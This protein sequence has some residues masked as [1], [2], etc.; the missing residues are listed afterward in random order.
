MQASLV[1]RR[2]ASVTNGA[3]LVNG[4]AG[5][6]SSSNTG[7]SDDGDRLHQRQS[8]T[9]A[10]TSL[11][12]EQEEE[13][14]EVAREELLRLHDV[15]FHLQ[16]NRYIFTGYR[17]LMTSW[18]CLKS[19][20]YWHNE[21]INIL[22]HGIPLVLILVSIPYM[23]PWHVIT[24]PFL[25][26][27]HVVSTMAPWLGSFIYHLFMNHTKG[28]YL[29]HRL[30]QFDMLGIWVTQS[31]G[32]L[33]TVYASV[34]CLPGSFQQFVFVFYSMLSAISLYKALVATDPWQ[35][36]LSFTLQF[37][38]RVLLF[39]LRLTPLGGGDP[40]SIVHVILQDTLAIVGGAIGA[41]RIPERWLPGK[42]DSLGNGHHI[43][44]VLV[45]MAVVHMHIAARSDLV[46]MSTNGK[47]TTTGLWE[48]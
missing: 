34:F 16:F 31:F 27:S 8:S 3:V 45:V 23:L 24:V 21:T 48:S 5:S 10:K 18:Q 35:R 28:E 32:A 30:L 15:P 22:T 42:V 13:A 29:Y 36:R 39:C 47:C 46:W 1:R 7:G 37:C 9:T 26:Y 6:S 17:P 19:L 4:K 11:Q 41:L 33:T 12:Q 25:P 20:F 2:E 43:M 44:H 40:T 38:F 14:E